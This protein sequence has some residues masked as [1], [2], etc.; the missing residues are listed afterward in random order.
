MALDDRAFAEQ[1][2][3]AFEHRLGAVLEVARRFSFPLRQRHARDYVQEGLA[4]VGDAAHTIH[5]LAGQGINLGLLDVQVLAEELLRARERELP[6]AGLAV[7]QRY[8]RRRKAHNLA[9]MAAMEGF[10]R[11]FAQPALPLRW[12]RNTG[13]RWLDQAA[14]LKHQIMKKAMG[15]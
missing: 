12:A 7:L 13:M 6:L 11:L 2:G 9:M 8:Q 3:Q 1:L 15:L 5:P 4:L 14:P 10:K